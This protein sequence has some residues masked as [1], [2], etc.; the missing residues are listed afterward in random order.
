[1]DEQNISNLPEDQDGEQQSYQEEE[2]NSFLGRIDL[3]DHNVMKKIILYFLIFLS[4]A[5][6]IA[7]SLYITAPQMRPFSNLPMDK[8]IPILDFLEKNEIDYDLNHGVLS[9]NADDVHSVKVKLAREGIDL[10]NSR[11]MHFLTKDT[12]FG[13]SQQLESARLKFEQEENIAAT[14][15]ELTN[16][17]KAKVILALP[18]S[19]IFA[20]QKQDPTATVVVNV[21]QSYEL[22][23]DEVDAIVDIVSSAV[24]GLSPT[25]ITVTDQ[26][27]RLLNSGSKDSLSAKA[28]REFELIRKKE[29]EYINKIDI[30]LS[31]ILGKANF[32]TQVNVVMDFTAIEETSKKYNPELP[33]IRSEMSVN[34]YNASG[35]NGGVPGALTNQP[36]AS[37]T[38]PQEAIKEGTSESS[39]ILNNHSESTKN[40]E[41]DTT[42]SHK[43]NQ[44]GVI[45][46]VSVSVAVNFKKIPLD[47]YKKQME[48]KSV[49]SAINLESKSND[50]S[51]EA[52]AGQNKEKEKDIKKPKDNANNSLNAKSSLKKEDIGF[53]YIPRT[54]VEI[55]NIRAML[56]GAIGYSEKRGDILNIVNFR[57]AALDLPE[58]GEPSV[59][60]DEEFLYNVFKITALTVF[61]LLFILFVLKP[62][63]GKILSD[64]KAKEESLQ[65]AEVEEQF[66]MNEEEMLDPDE[67]TISA[68]GE[69][70]F[71]GLTNDKDLIRLIKKLVVDE[72]GLAIK[73]IKNWIDEDKVNVRKRL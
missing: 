5:L 3:S 56:E 58:L 7:F 69:M 37:S 72:P 42:I 49:L 71:P 14:I 57:F 44:I 48:D 64:N 30:L 33:S 17:T 19:N 40:Y 36:P 66:A 24:R 1:M 73:V 61:S 29:Q 63:I 32:T 23:P 28:S 67:Y 50:N 62:L 12:G 2:Q 15:E 60:S 26:Y 46:Q 34:N 6:L 70:N 11:K 21:K 13:V 53:V 68:S 51:T 9:L 54:E 25:N 65:V 22:P 31:P 8:M 39:N 41:L 18:E 35:S 47:E 20:R 4:L 43:K 38:I 59:W 52:D 27:S 16:I 55:N 10:E 45:R